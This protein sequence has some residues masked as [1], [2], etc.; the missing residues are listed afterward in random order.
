LQQVRDGSYLSELRRIVTLGASHVGKCDRCSACGFICEICNNEADV[1]YPFDV[2]NTV[3]VR[4]GGC[5]LCFTCRNY[6]VL[7][8][9]VNRVFFWTLAVGVA[10]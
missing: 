9:V 8:V 7:N 2:A 3:T 6:E 5:L 4:N 10:R 1:I